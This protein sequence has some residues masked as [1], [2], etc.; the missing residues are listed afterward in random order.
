MAPHAEPR[1]DSAHFRQQPDCADTLRCGHTREILE[2]YF[3]NRPIRDE[4]LIVQG[5][6]LAGVG[7]HSYSEGNATKGSEE[8]E[9]FKKG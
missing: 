4:Y 7:A 9:R 5:G 1:H 6:K 3:E 8:A 2:C